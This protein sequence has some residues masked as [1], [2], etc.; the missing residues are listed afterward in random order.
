[1]SRVIHFE[2]HA[3]DPQRAINFYQTLFDWKMTSWGGETEYWMIV[4]G[5]EDQTGINGGLLRRPVPLDGRVANAFVCTVDVASLDDSL[6]VM[7]ANGGQIALEKMAVPGMGWLAYGI[8]TE[9]NTFGMMQVDG[10][11]SL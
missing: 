7:L 1:M 6:A 4:T 3:D 8:D 5:P 10:S 2:I 9:G 11:A